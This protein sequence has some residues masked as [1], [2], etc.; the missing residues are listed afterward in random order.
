MSGSPPANW[1]SS[2]R[3]PRP[4]AI[5]RISTDKTCSRTAS[6]KPIGTADGW[7]NRALTA[8][9]RAGSRP[10]D[11]AVAI[12]Q[13]VPLILRGQASVISKSPQMTPDVDEDLL[14]RLTD[15][16]SKDDWFSAR[17]SEGVQTGK[18]VGIAADSAT[19]GKKS[20]RAGY[21]DRL[22]ATARMAAELMRSE[23]GPEIAVIEAGGWDT[24]ANQGGAKGAWPHGWRA[25]T[26]RL[27]HWPTGWALSGRKQ[28]FWSSRN[29]A[30]PRPSTARAAPITAL[31]AVH[32][33]WVARFA[34]DR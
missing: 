33:S 32:S 6:T 24:H 26:R 14:M 29:S 20:A 22:G 5:G 30:G 8:L 34:A 23:G 25:L 2:T 4:I 1:W 18:M 3:W 21:P 31:A 17:L 7:L 27:N 10:A 13:N 28:R 16:Y 19:M 15:L 12:S 9:P 11:R